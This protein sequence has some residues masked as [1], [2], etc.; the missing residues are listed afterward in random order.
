MIGFPSIIFI[1]VRSS[2][3]DSISGIDKGIE[4][5]VLVGIN[6]AVGGGKVGQV[7]HRDIDVAEGGAPSGIDGGL[8]GR[9]SEIIVERMKQQGGLTASA[10]T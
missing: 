1:I 2:A 5:L 4:G 3:K 8:F 9:Q 6:G 7:D 10:A